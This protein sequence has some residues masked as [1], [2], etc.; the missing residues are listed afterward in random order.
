MADLN[1]YSSPLIDGAAGGSPLPAYNRGITWLAILTSIFG[2]LATYG[3]PSRMTPFWYFYLL[4]SLAF[5]ATM[6]TSIGLGRRSPKSRGF[7][8]IPAVV[9]LLIIVVF[10]ITVSVLARQSWGYLIDVTPRLI[11]TVAGWI[12]ATAFTMILHKSTSGRR[13]LVFANGLAILQ[14]T[15]SVADTIS[16]S[17]GPW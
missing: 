16:L 17:L 15:T 11:A 14:A 9:T 12:A 6:L 10:A 7:S 4:P 2:L 8:V 13:G 5:L 1:P 3:Y